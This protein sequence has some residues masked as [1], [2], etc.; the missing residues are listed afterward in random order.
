MSINYYI[1]NYDNLMKQYWNKYQNYYY[2]FNSTLKDLNLNEWTANRGLLYFYNPKTY[3]QYKINYIPLGSLDPLTNTWTWS[4]GS[5]FN[6]KYY[7]L[8]TAQSDMKKAKRYMNQ[9]SS[10]L[11]KQQKLDMDLYGAQ[12]MINLISSI[13][14]LR[15]GGK[16]VRRLIYP[17]GQYV[18]VLVEDYKAAGKRKKRRSKSKKRHSKKRKSKRHSKKRS[19]SKRR[20]SKKR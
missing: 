15:L 20:K 12:K 8:R 18:Y 14:T 13:A 7:E 3:D 16:T 5:Q 6:K 2:N 4:W 9:I 11:V 17:N 10:D 1:P 19:K